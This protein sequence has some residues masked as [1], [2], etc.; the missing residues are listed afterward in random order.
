MRRNINAAVTLRAGQA[1][2]V[3]ILVD[4]AADRTEAVVAVGKYVG[5]RELLQ[6]AGTC[7]LDDAYERDI[8]GGQCIKADL[9]LLRVAG[10]IVFLKD[11]IR[12]GFLTRFFFID[13]FSGKRLQLQLRLRIIRNQRF[14][15]YQIRSA[16]IQLDH[17]NLLNLLMLYMQGNDIPS[18]VRKNLLTIIANSLFKIKIKKRLPYANY[19]LDSDEIRLIFVPASS[20]L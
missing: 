18:S 15:V 8:M 20:I 6:S 4:G 16:V 14:S 3:V 19:F 12:H 11:T 7:R 1:E 10:C 5:N 9:Q 13:L 2:H 17:N